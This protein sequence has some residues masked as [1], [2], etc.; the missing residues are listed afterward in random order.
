M[1]VTWTDAVLSLMNSASP[2]W[3]LVRPSTRR[4]R[5]SRSR[6]DRPHGSAGS[7]DGGG[8]ERPA[9]RAIEVE[10]GRPGHGQGPLARRVA[11]I[12]R[13]GRGPRAAP[14]RLGGVAAVA[15]DRRRP[16]AAG[17]QRPSDDC[18]AAR[19]GRQRG[20]RRRLVATVASRQFR[21]RQ[22]QPAERSRRL[23]RGRVRRRRASIRSDRA[24][25]REVVARIAADRADCRSA[26]RPRGEPGDL[27]DEAGRIEAPATPATSFADRLDRGGSGSSCESSVQASARRRSATI[28]SAHPAR[29]CDRSGRDVRARRRCRRG[30]P[31]PGA[32][33]DC[34]TLSGPIRHARNAAPLDRPSRWHHPNGRGCTRRAPSA[35]SSHESDA[36]I[37]AASRASARI[38]RRPRSR[39]HS[40]RGSARPTGAFVLTAKYASERAG[41]GD[42]SA[43]ASAR[44]ASVER[45]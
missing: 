7:G 32:A 38:G 10:A 18:R 13:R 4:A 29:P 35:T 5:T 31:D 28:S 12:V 37:E 8:V 27:G 22:V 21:V 42:R 36:A 34:R 19:D 26:G 25:G 30:R 14:R 9:R 33:V 39:A 24:P 23:A 43:L 17:D 45:R 1:W 15:Q 3:R 6:S 20:P 2:I 11:P 40:G 44:T 41:R 16:R